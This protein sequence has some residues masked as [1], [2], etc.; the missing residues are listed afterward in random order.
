MGAFMKRIRMYQVIKN[1]INVYKAMVHAGVFIQLSVFK[2][3]L[4]GTSDQSV[5][6][7]HHGFRV[8]IPEILQAAENAESHG[9]KIVAACEMVSNNPESASG[10]INALVELALNVQLSAMMA[11]QDSDLMEKAGSTVESAFEKVGD[12]IHKL[13]Q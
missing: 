7:I 3:A 10:F 2:K 1:T 5:E 4:K 12:S 13:Q 8:L 9:D 6:A 11:T